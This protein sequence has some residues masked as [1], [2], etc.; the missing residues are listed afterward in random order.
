MEWPERGKQRGGAEMRRAGIRQ[1]CC[2]S[3]DSNFYSCQFKP[4][5]NFRDD[6][7]PTD[8]DLLKAN[9]ASLKEL[10]N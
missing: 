3:K 7:K 6:V 5:D 2:Q 10:G 8:R 1:C 4:R 9:T